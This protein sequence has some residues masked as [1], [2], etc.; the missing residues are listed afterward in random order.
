MPGSPS[1]GQGS[2]EA[3]IEPWLE[4]GGV[5]GAA[6][7]STDGLL[8]AAAGNHGGEAEALAA[9]CAA[10]LAAAGGVFSETGQERPRLVAIEKAGRG[11]IIAPLG[12]E[13]FLIIAGEAA[14]LRLTGGQRLYGLALRQS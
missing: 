14:L 1:G 11:I 3:I 4:L 12:R 7:A 2:F 9:D 5:T 8:I 6:L 13:L 10:V